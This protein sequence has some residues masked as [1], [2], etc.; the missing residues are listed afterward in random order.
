MDNTYVQLD[1]DQERFE[2]I[3]VTDQN[4][5]QDRL[6][7]LQVR[8]FY[9]SLIQT[10]RRPAGRRALAVERLENFFS[11]YSHLKILFYI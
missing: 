1:E 4:T 8:V 10:T 6:D 9:S 5:F 2:K 11:N 7:G 3:Q